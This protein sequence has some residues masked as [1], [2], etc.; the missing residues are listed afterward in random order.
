[1]WCGVGIMLMRL[2]WLWSSLAGWRNSLPFLVIGLFILLGTQFFFRRIAS[3]NIERIQALPDNA[4]LFAFQSWTSYP[5]VVFMMGLGI[6]LRATEVPR[7]WLAGVYL[8]IGAGLFVAGSGYFSA[9][10]SA[11]PKDK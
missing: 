7:T 2:S 6:G 1:M 10:M 3:R 9:L 11:W 5:L 8:A 4:C